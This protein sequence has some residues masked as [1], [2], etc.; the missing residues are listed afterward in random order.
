[1]SFNGASLT[2]RR[3]LP[4]LV[5]LPLLPLLTVQGRRV[6]RLTP[7]LPEA[8]GPDNGLCGAHH[9]SV[10]LR[11]LAVGE[12]PVAGVGV[13]TH[14]EAI[15]A[16][17]A[18]ALSQQLARPVSWRACGLNGVTVA[19]AQTRLLPLVP[20]EPVDLLLVAFGVNDSTSFQSSD[21]WQGDL[22]RLLQALQ[23]RCGPRLT[24][25]SGVPPMGHF[26][27]LP[28][29]LRW[30]L[31][32]KAAA[33]DRAAATMAAATPGVLHVPM[34]PDTLAPGL[35]ASDNYHP[36]A[37]GCTVWG[38]ELAR[39]AASSPFLAPPGNGSIV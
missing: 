8:A 39:A 12:S 30:V 26:L 35:M 7:R 21:R 1:M 34:R 38:L 10:A 31:G 6:R 23:E 2:M 28:Q 13:G 22:A 19:Q 20:A 14:E 16:A 32:M 33:L 11:L 24:L 9:G 27:S 4:E 17:L 15:A 29:P 37:A 25:L 36:S 18:N 3:W 5:A